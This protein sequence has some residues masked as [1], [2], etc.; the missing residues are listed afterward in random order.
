MFQG[1][2][3]VHAAG[4]Q[5]GYQ[6][7]R[8]ALR[9]QV[10]ELTEETSC[11]DSNHLTPMDGN[12]R[13]SLIPLAD[14]TVRRPGKGCPMPTVH[15]C[16]EPASRVCLFW[17]RVANDQRWDLVSLCV[18]QEGQLL[19]LV[20]TVLHDCRIGFGNRRCAIK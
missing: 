16:A 18:S 17:G 3:A 2:T 5:R 4:Q 14:L 1:V 8:V 10:A 20:R 19:L 9:P 13:R 6:I 7:S 15:P 12:L 11:A